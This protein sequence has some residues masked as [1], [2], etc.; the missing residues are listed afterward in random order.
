MPQQQQRQQFRQAL[1]C[2]VYDDE[3][4][5]KYGFSYGH[6]RDGA[7]FLPF[8][9]SVHIV[10]GPLALHDVHADPE[11]ARLVP[12][13]EPAIAQDTARDSDSD[14]ALPT[15]RDAKRDLPE[16][17]VPE[18]LVE[19]ATLSVSPE[20]RASFLLEQLAAADK[21]FAVFCKDHMRD[22]ASITNAE[23]QRISG[24]FVL[25][26]KNRVTT[27]A[28]SVMK[29]TDKLY[30]RA[31]N[32]TSLRLKAKHSVLR[33]RQVRDDRTPCT[34]GAQGLP[35]STVFVEKIYDS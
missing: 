15:A 6:E 3:L 11:E 19:D 31:R 26:R 4:T 7:T 28:D 10:P 1:S 5:T 2:I 9:S 17:T 32:R 14:T 22:A 29:M 13:P 33:S 25:E 12:Q 27:E 21:E 34:P 16:E 20:I 35:S 30:K 8:P 23:L 18:T 24:L